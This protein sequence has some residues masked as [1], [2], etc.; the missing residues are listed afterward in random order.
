MPSGPDARQVR[1]QATPDSVRVENPSV[2]EE[3]SRSFY[4]IP[5]SKNTPLEV[6][7]LLK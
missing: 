4:L 1:G 3:A 7:V 2:V 6:K 5:H